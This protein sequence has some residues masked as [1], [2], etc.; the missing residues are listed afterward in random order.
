MADKKVI[1]SGTIV[2][3]L[4]EGTYFMSMRHYQKEIKKKLGFKAYPGTLNLR[5][6]KKQIGSLK[7]IVPIKINGYKKN[8]KTFG[9]ASCYKAKISSINGSIILPDLTKHSN[10]IEFIAPVHLKSG[11]KIKDGDKIKIELT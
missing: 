4:G 3:G 10:I 2:R 7:N 6:G 8:N 9:G 1:L 5:L 11:L